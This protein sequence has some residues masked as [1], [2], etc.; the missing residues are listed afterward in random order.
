MTKKQHDSSILNHT[1]KNQ[2]KKQLNESNKEDESEVEERK[3]TDCF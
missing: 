2:K 3:I 1:I